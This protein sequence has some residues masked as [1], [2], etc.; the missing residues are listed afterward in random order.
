[1][2]KFHLFLVLLPVKLKVGMLLKLECCYFNRKRLPTICET[3]VH[4]E[5]IIEK[6]IRKARDSFTMGTPLQPLPRSVGGKL[7]LIIYASTQ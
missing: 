6:E 7:H 5:S 2:I 4:N 1:M 3:P